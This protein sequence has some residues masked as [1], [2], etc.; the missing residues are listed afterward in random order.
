MKLIEQSE[1]SRLHRRA[2]E[3]SAASREGKARSSRSSQANWWFGQM[4]RAVEQACPTEEPK[5]QVEQRALP[6]APQ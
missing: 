5:R 3:C 1:L 2:Y 6:L 4:R